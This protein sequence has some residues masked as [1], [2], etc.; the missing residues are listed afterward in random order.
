ML[1]GKRIA[2][3]LVAM[4]GGAGLAFSFC[5]PRASAQGI[6]AGTYSNANYLNRYICNEQVNS[7]ALGTN[8]FFAGQA[9]VFANGSG[10]FISGTLQAPISSGT[11][12]FIPSNAPPDNFCAFNLNAA[13][14]SY[15]CSSNGVCVDVLSWTP[16]YTATAATTCS[17]T[18]GSATFLTSDTF[19]L[20]GFGARPSG[21][22]T[23][24]EVTSD[25]FLNKGASGSGYCKK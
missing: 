9:E 2:A 17:A 11:G 4:L 20:R 5:V 14:S 8:Q 19:A 7:G 6:P 12:V 25:N 24:A 10:T 21:A 22:S 13:S 15:V 3:R 23:R 1:K 16:A 18:F